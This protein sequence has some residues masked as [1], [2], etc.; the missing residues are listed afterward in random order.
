MIQGVVTA[1]IRHLKY[2]ECM[3]IYLWCL[4]VYHFAE[5]VHLLVYLLFL[6][7]RHHTDVAI[8]LDFFECFLE[9]FFP[10]L[11]HLS[12]RSVGFTLR[13]VQEG[14]TQCQLVQ[15]VVRVPRCLLHDETKLWTRIRHFG[16][17]LVEISNRAL[18]KF[19]W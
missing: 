2:R 9:M 16:V 5:C 3:V 6:L 8:P 4:H 11:I 7:Y 18:T 1:F 19:D 14:V 10:R 17:W 13:W 15:E 12:Y